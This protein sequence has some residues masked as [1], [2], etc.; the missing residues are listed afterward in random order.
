MKHA[1]ST[2]TVT[3]TAKHNP[4]Q[5]T[6]HVTYQ[7]Q[8]S[9]NY[10]PPLPRWSEVHLHRVNSKPPHLR[11]Q[12]PL[13]SSTVTCL[14]SN[15]NSPRLFPLTSFLSFLSSPF[16]SLIIV[17]RSTQLVMFERGLGKDSRGL[18]SAG[19]CHRRRRTLVCESGSNIHTAK[20]PLLVFI[21]NH[22]FP[23]ENPSPSRF[24]RQLF[25]K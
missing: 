21:S 12:R 25:P 1:L 2:Y 15:S 8:L 3:I 22:P 13:N 7:S 6:P 9:N 24:D 10:L 19:L 23:S 14:P 17:V 16:L 18:G 11:L 5:T 20:P 4:T